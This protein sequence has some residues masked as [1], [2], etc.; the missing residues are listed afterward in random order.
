M[1]QVE[2]GLKR[3]DTAAFRAILDAFGDMPT[4]FAKFDGMMPSWRTANVY[5]EKEARRCK[6][7]PPRFPH[8]FSTVNEKERKT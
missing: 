7:V 4:I 1:N 2:E 8:S 6:T 5:F 3:A